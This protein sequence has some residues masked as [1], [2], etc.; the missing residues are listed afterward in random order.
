MYHSGSRRKSVGTVAVILFIVSEGSDIELKDAARDQPP[1]P[2]GWPNVVPDV[3][4]VIRVR[5]D[6]RHNERAMMANT[7]TRAL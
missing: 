4:Y 1:L 7:H 2:K 6:P 3:A 5:S